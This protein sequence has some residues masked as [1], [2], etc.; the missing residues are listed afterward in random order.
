MDDLVTIT[1]DGQDIRTPKGTL[2]WEACKTQGIDIPIFC[3][4]TKLG[5]V[6]A[7]RTCLVEVDGMRG[8]ITACSTP[9]TDGM[10]VRTRS[11]VV[12]KA[13]RGIFEFL[14]LNHPLD[15]PICDRGGECPLQDQTF[16]Y[17]PGTG[18]KY[19]MTVE[20][21]GVTPD[22]SIVVPGLHDY[23]PNNPAD[24]AYEQQN[25][26]ILFSILGPDKVCRHH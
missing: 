4:H 14:L 12:E 19:R 8:P 22:V 23:N 26:A 21:P 13:Q 20:G 3:Y 25:D 5:P 1:V 24:V 18:E 6:G 2:L 11:P 10:K 17:G 15:C 7:C 9:V 16:S